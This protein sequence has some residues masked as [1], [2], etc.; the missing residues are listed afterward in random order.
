MTN[1][2]RIIT[3]AKLK[4]EA[5]GLDAPPYPGHLGEKIY[6]HTSVEAWNEWL[7]YL[8][9]LINEGRL[10]VDQADVKEVL[11]KEMVEFLELK[12]IS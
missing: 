4:R 7:N 10:A 2:T 1:N 9:M 5:P 8:T 11:K 6:H 12:N 3:C